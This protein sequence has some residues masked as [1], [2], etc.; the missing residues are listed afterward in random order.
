LSRFEKEGSELQNAQEVD[1][2]IHARTPP[3]ESEAANAQ[4]TPDKLQLA[5]YTPSAYLLS[6]EIEG[7]QISN[8]GL[9]KY[10]RHQS[11]CLTSIQRKSTWLRGWP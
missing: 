8:A 4:P 1:R 2:M 10:H 9:F 6:G 11:H 3:D 7:Y 5:R